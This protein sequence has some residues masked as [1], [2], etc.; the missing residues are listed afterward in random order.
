MS[1]NNNQHSASPERTDGANVNVMAGCC[2]DGL[3]IWDMAESRRVQHHLSVSAAA[4][5]I[6]A[7][8]Y[9]ADAAILEHVEIWISMCQRD[10]KAVETA[11]RNLYN[12]SHVSGATGTEL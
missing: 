8:L 5:G 10:A 2:I 1:S 3:P 12:A 9:G 7:D 4:R 6:C 11:S